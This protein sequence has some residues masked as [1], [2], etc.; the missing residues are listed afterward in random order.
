M[1]KACNFPFQCTGYAENFGFFFFRDL[2]TQ[3]MEAEKYKLETEKAQANLNSFKEEVLGIEKEVSLAKE[4]RAQC[5]M[6][7]GKD[8][9]VDRDTNVHLDMKVKPN[10][11]AS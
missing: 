9:G 10:L 2:K 3:L 1:P 6:D 11:Y 5:R 7:L 8:E 4:E